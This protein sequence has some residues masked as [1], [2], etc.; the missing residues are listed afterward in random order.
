[1]FSK[2]ADWVIANVGHLAFV[3]VALALGALG[4]GLMLIVAIVHLKQTGTWVPL[5][6][7]LTGIAVFAGAM[8]QIR[9]PFARALRSSE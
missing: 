9:V 2:F 3:F 5:I 7:W 4:F 6:I 1:M 8:W